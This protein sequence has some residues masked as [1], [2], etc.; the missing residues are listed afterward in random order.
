MMPR[1]WNKNEKHIKKTDFVKE[2]R[3]RLLFLFFYI[4][5]YSFSISF[6][7]TKRLENRRLIEIEFFGFKSKFHFG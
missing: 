6:F 5:F 4:L 3:E 7:N 2:E 1:N